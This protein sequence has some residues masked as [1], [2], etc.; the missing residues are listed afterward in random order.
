MSKNPI[1]DYKSTIFKV[2]SEN[3]QSRFMNEMT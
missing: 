3:D 2:V 1:N